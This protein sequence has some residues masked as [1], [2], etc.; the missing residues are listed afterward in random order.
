VDGKCVGV[1]TSGSYGHYTQKSLAFVYAPPEC[2][3]PGFQMEI[4]LLG[5]RRKA[6]VLEEPVYDPAS[7]TMR[8]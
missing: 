2:T 7:A 1:A 3:T 6:V 8:V 4:G 5:E